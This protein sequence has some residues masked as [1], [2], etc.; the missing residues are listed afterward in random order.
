M[1]TNFLKNGIY[2]FAV[3]LLF[4]CSFSFLSASDESVVVKHGGNGSHDDCYD[5][6]NELDLKKLCARTIK[7]KC[8]DAKKIDACSI[9]AEN[10]CVDNQFATPGIIVDNLNAQ[11]ICTEN[12]T[13]TVGCIGQF[14]AN[15]ACIPGSLIAGDLKQCAK[16]VAAIDFAVNS[17]YTLGDIINWDT[18]IDDP[19]GNVSFSPN[20][21]YTAPYSGYYLISVQIDQ[22]NING[23]KP[24]I[25]IPVTNI[26]I[27]VNGIPNLQTYVPYLSFHDAQQGN[28]SSLIHLTAGDVVTAKYNVYVMTDSF[29]FSPYVGQVT[30][31]ST[32]FFKIHLLSITCADL[33][34]APCVVGCAPSATGCE[35]FGTGSCTPC[36]R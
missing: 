33:P 14:T 6:H 23:V 28:S 34:C 16:Y 10:L 2:I 25:G 35:P 30:I 9:H 36:N 5:C 19:N 24:I 15:T 1:S 31:D 11:N 12:L 17:V 26:G 4:S 13:A 27:E 22:F 32:S 7:A 29:G 3:T 20:T 8:I 21:Y 18:I